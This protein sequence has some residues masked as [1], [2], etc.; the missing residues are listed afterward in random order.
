VIFSRHA[1]MP[2]SDTLSGML[3]A[4]SS[5]PES[6]MT[7]PS[8]AAADASDE[9]DPPLALNRAPAGWLVEYPPTSVC[10]RVGECR[11]A[12]APPVERRVAEADWRAALS[13]S[14]AALASVAG[15]DLPCC[16][17]GADAVNYGGPPP[18]VADAKGMP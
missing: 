2:N 11:G 13:A 9:L 12:T 16:R 4:E 10:A 3:C 5:L 15:T 17:E 7:P 6:Q 14:A 8:T 18:Y 1:L